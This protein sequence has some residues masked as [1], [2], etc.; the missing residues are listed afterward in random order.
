MS[1]RQAARLCALLLPLLAPGCG[2]HLTGH[3]T[4]LPP[5]IKKIGIPTFANKT[6]RPDLE[7]RLTARIISEFITRGRYH[8]SS[9]EEGVDAVLKG[10]ILAYVQTPVSLTP[11]GRASR[12]EI[13]I[14]ARATLVQ[15]SDDKV[16]WQ[17][18]HFVFR[19]QYEVSSLSSGIVSQEQVAVDQ[20]V[21]DFAQAV[22]ASILEGF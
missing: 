10:E 20:V 7:Q 3:S 5:G 16:L 18:D 6:D 13:L 2:Y 15:T 9:S 22:V 8:I 11:Q 4:V 14:N 19:R 17:D 1:A 21:D 12:Y